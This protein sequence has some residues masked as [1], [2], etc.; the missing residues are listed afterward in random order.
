MV[1]AELRDAVRHSP[2]VRELLTE[3]TPGVRAGQVTAVEG[4]ERI[5]AAFTA[6]L[7]DRD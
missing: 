7:T 3:I 6:D 1:D 2:R 5:M 4:A